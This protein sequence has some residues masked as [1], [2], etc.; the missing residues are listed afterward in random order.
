MRPICNDCILIEQTIKCT[1][2]STNTKKAISDLKE[3]NRKKEK[4]QQIML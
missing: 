2:T 4:F 3:R 1:S